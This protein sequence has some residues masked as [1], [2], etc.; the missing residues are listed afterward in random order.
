MNCKNPGHEEPCDYELCVA[1]QE[2]C[3]EFNEAIL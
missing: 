3:K 1:C 2:D